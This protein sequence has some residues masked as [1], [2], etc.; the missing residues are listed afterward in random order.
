M[1]SNAT[2]PRAARLL[3]TLFAGDDRSET[4]ADRSSAPIA[5]TLTGGGQ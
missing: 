4:I 1:Q 3:A 5:T 2:P